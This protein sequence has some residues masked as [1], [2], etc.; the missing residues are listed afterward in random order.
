M[1]GMAAKRDGGEILVGLD[2]GTTKVAAVVGE[3]TD[4]GIEVIG[5]GQQLCK[6]SRKGLALNIEQ[7]AASIKETIHEAEQMAGC[8]IG[9]VHVGISG[10]HVQGI[11]MSG[12]VAVKG[13]EVAN[14]DVERVKENARAINLPKDRDILHVL[15]QDYIIDGQDGIREPVG[16]SGVR[17]EAKVHIITASALQIQNILKCCRLCDL[18]VDSVTLEHLAAAEAVLQ[19]GE[20]ELGVALVDI[21]G[22][23]TNMA[24]YVD[25]TLRHTAVIGMGGGHITND[26]RVGLRTIEAEAERL[27]KSHACALGS[28]VDAEETILVPRVGPRPP[29][30]VPRS[31]L[32]AIVS[33][34]VEEILSHVQQEIEKSGYGDMLH[35]GVV[36]TGGAAMLKGLAEMAEEVM[37]TVVRVGMPMGV[38]GMVDMV[39]NPSFAVASGLL[40]H[41][42]R[43]KAHASEDIAPPTK[44]GERKGAGKRFWETVKQWF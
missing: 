8:Q 19:D 17:L 28:M 10:P 31:A 30:M 27:K 7:T 41:A 22:S 18:A 44:P 13:G 38:G 29:E 3:V 6:G 34:R 14:E 33:P 35:G 26:I 15:P 36:L 23:I 4:N 1:G 16:I 42:A 25:G 32:C 5:V 2:I 39:Q 37:Q 20:K 21:G 11:D 43:R 40:L 24:I 12:L 9:S